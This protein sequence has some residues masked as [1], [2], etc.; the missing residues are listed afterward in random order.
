ME[1]VDNNAFS[2]NLNSNCKNPSKN[3]VGIGNFHISKVSSENEDYHTF[4]INLNEKV[5]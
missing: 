2:I 1:N 3:I 5:K 4:T